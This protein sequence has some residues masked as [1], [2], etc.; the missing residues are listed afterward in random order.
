M[1]LHRGVSKKRPCVMI[2]RKG[3]DKS[4]SHKPRVQISRERKI[5]GA[6]LYRAKTRF[7]FSDSTLCSLCVLFKEYIVLQKE[8]Q[9]SA[10]GSQDTRSLCDIDI[11][12]DVD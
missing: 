3:R 1:E 12:G 6:Q 7:S 8:I 11:L 5:R 2:Q 10:S 9:K 4:E